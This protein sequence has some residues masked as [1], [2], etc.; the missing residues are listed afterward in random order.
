MPPSG[1]ASCLLSLNHR[2]NTCLRIAFSLLFNTLPQRAPNN[3]T[4]H[5]PAPVDAL[6]T[7]G[8]SIP[9]CSTTNQLRPE[10]VSPALNRA[11]G[12]H[13]ALARCIQKYATLVGSR[14]QHLVTIIQTLQVATPEPATRQLQRGTNPLGFFVIQVHIILTGSGTAL[15]T[16][17]T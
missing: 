3:R 9:R 6:A 16:L 8:L 2:I 12:I 15:S 5:C 10:W 13:T 4:G 7:T 14:C 11:S 17:R 1:P